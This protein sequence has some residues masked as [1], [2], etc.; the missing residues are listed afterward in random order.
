MNSRL[1][2]ARFALA[3]A[4]ASLAALGACGS[5]SGDSAS[6]PELSAPAKLTLVSGDAQ[7]VVNAPAAAPAP[8]IV[9]VTDPKNRPLKDVTVAWAASDPSAK[10]SAATSN[11]DASGQAQV[12][13]TLGE[14]AG[15]QTVTATVAQIAGERVVFQAK[16][17]VTAISGSVTRST[18]APISFSATRSTAATLLKSANRVASRTTI[19]GGAISTNTVRYSQSAL[20]AQLDAHRAPSR[21]LIVHIDPG[22]IGATRAFATTTHELAISR[23]AV[24]RAVARFQT[25][26]IAMRPEISP[27]IMAA[28]VTVP[29]SV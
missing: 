1:V 9:M 14:T 27:A 6:A 15:A 12:T 7:S 20:R 26:G 22:F 25:R 13:W 18:T 21:R 23:D 28:R 11:T 19:G 3:V 17:G 24:Q 8:L 16:N 4:T 10:L 5:S 2:G 29:D